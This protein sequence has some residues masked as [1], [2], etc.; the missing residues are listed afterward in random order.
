MSKTVH[1]IYIA[2]FIIICAFTVI[3]L[4]V[5]GYNYYKAPIEQRFFMQQNN[6]LKPS[7]LIGHGLGIFG[8]FFM[9]VGVASY[10]IRKRIKALFKFGYLKYW[11][12]FHIFLCTLGPILILYHT[13][14]KFGGIVV[15]SFW[16]MVAVVLS[17]VIGRF[18]YVQIPHTIQGQMIGMNELNSLSENLSHQL[19]NDF[20]IPEEIF[21]RIQEISSTYRYKR[22][23]FTTG[24]SLIIKDYIG[25]KNVLRR[26]KHELKVAGISKSKR[27]EILL[28]AKSKL[29][30][31][32]R[33][34]MLQTM[35]KL[36]GYWHVVHLPFALIMFII[37]VI[38]IAVEIVFGYKWIF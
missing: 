20:A 13:A 35:Q 33:I 5:N 34:G 31:S 28:T 16:S 6:L 25:I 22:V 23:K 3:I 9:I 18:L 12:E 27:K 19:K 10:M 30:V 8:S 2:S 32:R 15:V 11:L 24:L 38:H 4:S 37:M 1:R 36:F 29:V 17:G 21:A 26:L 14:F 7:G